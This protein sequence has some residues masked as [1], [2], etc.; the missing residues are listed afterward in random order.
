MKKVLVGFS[1]LGKLRKQMSGLI[2]QVLP[3]VG[4]LKTPP[5]VSS[6]GSAVESNTART[7]IASPSF[8]SH[9]T[10]DSFFIR[11]IL[12][13]QFLLISIYPIAH[14]LGVICFTLRVP[15]KFGRSY[16]WKIE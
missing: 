15:V 6:L 1:G 4:S 5:T 11:D 8:S 2:R 9:M 13:D 10:T 14:Q 3:E 12:C 7:L 16:I